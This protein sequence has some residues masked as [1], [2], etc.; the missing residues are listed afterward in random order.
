MRAQFRR[1]AQRRTKVSGK[2]RRAETGAGEV[3]MFD[4]L[5]RNDAATLTVEESASSQV[6][7]EYQLA[8]KE[9]NECTQDSAWYESTHKIPSTV[10]IVNG[11]VYAAV[12]QNQRADPTAA[13][14]RSRK[15][16]ARQVFCEKL[17]VRAEMRAR[18]GLVR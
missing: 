7:R 2:C 15:E 3:L 13:M 18:A 12:N 6:E 8:K 5:T 11:R 1:A 17:R 10:H 16:R 9:Y 14:L 4:W